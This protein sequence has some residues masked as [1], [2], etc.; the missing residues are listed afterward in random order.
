MGWWFRIVTA[1]LTVGD[2][3]TNSQELAKRQLGSLYPCLYPLI[4]YSLK[5]VS[6]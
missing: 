6:K 3:L 2:L 4:Y 1:L 5:K